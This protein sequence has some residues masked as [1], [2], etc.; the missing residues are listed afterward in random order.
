VWSEH[1]FTH[2]SGTLKILEMRN[3][4]FMKY[5][6]IYEYIYFINRFII[7]CAWG[8]APWN[9]FHYKSSNNSEKLLFWDQNIKQNKIILKEWPSNHF[10]QIWMLVTKIFPTWRAL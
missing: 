8:I 1:Q 6:Y 9:T 7:I 5:E 2:W 4:T 3:N 10:E